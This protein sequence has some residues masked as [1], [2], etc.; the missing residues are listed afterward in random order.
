MI[1]VASAA[2]RA[3]AADTQPVSGRWTY[4]DAAAP[5]PAPH[6]LGA[7]EFRGA[8]RFDAR[9]GLSQFS[10]LSVEQDSSTVYR[11]LDEFFN[12]QLRGRMSFRLRIRDADHLEL[13]Y[14][15]GAYVALPRCA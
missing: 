3:V 6:C 8:R 2:G 1:V 15:G 4:D 14:K 7:T 5:G 13:E 10:N 9:G 11:V 12:V